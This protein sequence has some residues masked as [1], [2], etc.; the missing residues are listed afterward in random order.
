MI[1]RL[2]YHQGYMILNK[3]SKFLHDGGAWSGVGGD[4]RIYPGWDAKFF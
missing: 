3:S 2:S 1:Q 4:S